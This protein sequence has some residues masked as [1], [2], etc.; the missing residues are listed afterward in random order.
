M[1]PLTIAVL[2][3][4]DLPVPPRLYGGIER[5][6]YL[7]VEGLVERGHHVSLF[8]HRDSQTSATLYPYPRTESIS[9][10]GLGLN[11]LAVARR[12]LTRQLDVLHSFGRLNTIA[13]LA[14]TRSRKFMSYQREIT[15]ASI[16]RATRIFGSRLEFTACS[17]HMIQPVRDL[18]RWHVIYNAVSMAA[19]TCQPHVDAE[20]P[21]VFLGRIESIKGTHAA[22]QVARR[23][24][25]RLIIAG[26]IADQAYFDRDVRPFVDGERIRYVGPVDDAAKNTLLGSAS[27]LLM[28]IDW[29]EPFGIV[30]AE[31]LACGTP[32]VGFARGSV[33]EVVIDGVTGWIVDDV[34]AMT[35][36]VGRLN[37]IDRRACRADAEQRFSAT[38]IVDQ[39]E[40]LYRGNAVA[41]DAAPLSSQVQSLS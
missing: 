9:A 21:L 35:A 33:P 40:T 4:P 8:A 39:Y 37:A 28:P 11:A 20:A 22:V 14:W 27:A 18:G 7:L 30:M 26:N 29:D 25:R 6:I 2:A 16:E 19:Y 13:P 17:R 10:L 41:L 1:T 3:D 23:S 38:A 12:L 32:V 24:G 15:R 5:V 34:A 31:A 36:A